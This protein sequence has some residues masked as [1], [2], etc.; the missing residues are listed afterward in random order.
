MGYIITGHLIKVLL[1]VFKAGTFYNHVRYTRS[2]Y[3]VKG[4]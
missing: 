3:N 2:V 1:V 4:K